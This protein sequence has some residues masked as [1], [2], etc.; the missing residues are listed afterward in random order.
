MSDVV[1]TALIVAAGS[2]ASAVLVS[3]TS[4][5]QRR[6]DK[7]EDWRRQDEVAARV[8]EATRQALAVAREA[9]AAVAVTSGKLDVIHT[10][11]NS[12]MTAAMQAELAATVRELASLREIVNLN[13]AAGREPSAAALAAIGAAEVRVRELEAAL[14]DR[15]QAQAT[16]DHQLAQHGPATPR[17]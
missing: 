15:L 1:W 5:R 11:V 6:A 16:V 8:T 13:R 2:A 4:G 10:L 14:R 9:A 12:N 3:V 17:A 7:R